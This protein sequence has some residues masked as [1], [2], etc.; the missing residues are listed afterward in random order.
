[1]NTLNRRI[2]VWFALAALILFSLC[3]AT[4]RSINSL[5]HQNGWVEHTYEVMLVLDKVI[6]NLKDIQTAGRGYVITGEDRYAEIVRTTDAEMGRNLSDLS[7]LVQD[8]TMQE[9]LV[10]QL[11][12]STR[13]VSTWAGEIIATYKNKGSA[14][15]S[16][17]VRTGVG[18]QRIDASVS[19]ISAMRE[20]ERELLAQRREQVETAVLITLGICSFGLLACLGI[21]LLVF[22]LIDRETLRR[23]AIEKTL[24]GTV[25][26]LEAANE[27]R[28]VLAQM[29][30]F[31]QGCRTHQ[32]IYELVWQNMPRIF[33]GCHGA[34]GIL[35]NSRNIID[36]T[37]TWGDISS[38]LSQFA[39]EDC[40]GMR[41][42]KVHI[43]TAGS[44][45]PDCAHLTVRM[46]ES[47]CVPLVAHGETLGMLYMASSDWGM[48]D[49]NQQQLLRTISEQISLALA[50]M[51]LQ[52]TLRM[53]TLRDPLT[54][55]FNRRYMESS[56]ERELLRAKR[57]SQQLSVLML[58]VDHF[59]RFNDTFGHDAGD[60][61]LKEFAAMLQKN[62]RG[63]DIACRFGGEEFILI[64]PTCPLDIAIKR[65]EKILADTRAL[66]IQHQQQSL[67]KI[68]VSI[69]IA[70]FPEHDD[71]IEGLLRLADKALYSAKREGRDRAV[72]ASAD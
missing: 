40:W 4:W 50:N 27:E 18:Q 71:D 69:G 6:L 36:V 32:E 58:D 24:H 9:K 53:Q 49:E 30:D 68:T 59:K 14:A 3:Y 51:K 25:S 17:M 31:L 10:P 52:E 55:L 1:M 34:L 33:P 22:W 56:L 37:I 28:R 43:V 38:T 2:I 44:P 47:A 23:E 16:A 57:N 26:R 41:R 61:L 54:S 13:E 19:L 21:L 62:V 48:L 45:E 65:A 70:V 11:L 7:E 29:S 46:P 39:P 35:S 64:L 5:N 8:N 12:I 66:N 63:E 20:H 42:G 60:L 15:A 67:G 72:V